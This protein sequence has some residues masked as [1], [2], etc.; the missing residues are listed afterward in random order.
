MRQQ[1]VTAPTTEVVIDVAAAWHWCEQSRQL[2]GQTPI[3]GITGKPAD[4]IQRR[5]QQ[6]I[7]GAVRIKHIV[8][9]LEEVIASRRLTELARHVKPASQ[10]ALFLLHSAVVKAQTALCQAVQ[11]LQELAHHPFG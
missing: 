7:F 9:D 4:T 3:T 8:L 2:V 10:K 5:A 1:T 11:H 6:S